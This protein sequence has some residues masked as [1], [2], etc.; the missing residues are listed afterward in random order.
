[1]AE[2]VFDS[3]MLA[4]LT[5]ERS[6]RFWGRD[7]RI[8]PYLVAKHLGDGQQLIWLSPLMTRPNYYIVRIDRGWDFDAHDWP[9]RLEEI[10]ELIEEECGNSDWE[11]YENQGFPVLRDGG[12]CWGH[13]EE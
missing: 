1:M 6:V 4:D 9:D 10:Y 13:F 12:S 5:K 3:K 2:A 11:G 8:K 7:Y